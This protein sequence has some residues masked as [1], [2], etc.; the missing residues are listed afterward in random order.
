MPYYKPLI[1]TLY[2]INPINICTKTDAYCT[3]AYTLSLIILTTYDAVHYNTHHLY[4]YNIT[5]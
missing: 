3:K 1:S 2:K 4:E 5:I